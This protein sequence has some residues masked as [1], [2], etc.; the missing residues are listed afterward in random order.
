MEKEGMEYDFKLPV[1]YLW[2][3]EPKFMYV[4]SGRLTNWKK[5]RVCGERIQTGEKAMKLHRIGEYPE[6]FHNSTKEAQ[7]CTLVFARGFI[8]GVAF[9]L[10]PFK[11][12]T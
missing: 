8:K 11:E 7:D 3:P 1:D 9:N 2:N 5:C 6:Y 10:E 12:E 4:V